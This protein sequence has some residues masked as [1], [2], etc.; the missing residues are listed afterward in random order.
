ML[1]LLHFFTFLK[2]KF[3]FKQTKQNFMKH[4]LTYEKI[5]KI[6]IIYLFCINVYITGNI[7]LNNIKFIYK[8]L[9]FHNISKNILL[10]YKNIIYLCVFR[11]FIIFLIT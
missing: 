8:F 2:Q 10:N 9:F 6:Y 1:E 4:T 7:L 5:Y 3:K 11:N